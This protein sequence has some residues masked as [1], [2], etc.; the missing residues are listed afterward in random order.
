M[1]SEETGVDI[2]KLWLEIKSE[3][4]GYVKVGYVKKW[5]T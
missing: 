1:Q 2:N 5:D 3:K 4:V